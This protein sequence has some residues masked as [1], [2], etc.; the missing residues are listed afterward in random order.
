MPTE[1]YLCPPATIG[2][3]GTEHADPFRKFQGIPGVE[4]SVS[5]RLWATWYGGGAGEDRHNYVLLAHSDG[6]GL[7]WSTPSL[8]ID[9][10]G[11]GPVRAFDPCLWHDPDGR[12]WLFWAQGYEHHADDRSGVWAIVA[13]DASGPDPIWSS[14][15]RL[16]DGI[17]MNKPLVLSSG[18]WLLPAAR[19]H[20]QASAGVCASTDHG[21]TWA[22]RGAA[23]VPAPG[24]RNC[25]EHMVVE[26]ANG[27]LWMLVRTK[28]G[29]GQSTS[30]DLGVSWTDVEP[31]TI[32]HPV[33]RFFLRRLSSGKLLLVKHGPMDRRTE[34]TELT[35]FL[36][37]DE[38]ASWSGGLVL[39]RR[40]HISYPDGVQSPDGNITI[41]YDRERKGAREVLLLSLT[42]ED[43]IAGGPLL[44]CTP[45]VVNRAREAPATD[46]S[47]GKP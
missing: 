40:S 36:S 4:R 5:G 2:A 38:G 35:A 7:A 18:E 17:M 14:P 32:P 1:P 19:W 43:I 10:D 6:G 37:S 46:A 11:E 20:T 24:D 29:I 41:I 39:D 27:D 23:S 3:P 34:R 8:V 12:L 47:L 44:R 26:K 25:D 16:C 15:E 28:Y 30:P 13:D 21:R 45:T 9:P 22:S 33:S 31:S 42:E